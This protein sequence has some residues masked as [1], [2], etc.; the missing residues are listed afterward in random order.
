[1]SMMP[2]TPMPIPS[3]GVFKF[4]RHALDGV[5]HVGDDMVASQGNL[6]AESDFLDEC[7]LLV[8]G[9]DAQIRAAEVHSN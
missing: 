4:L 6:G 5:A 2:G 8:H 1:M 3:S 7:A 9:C